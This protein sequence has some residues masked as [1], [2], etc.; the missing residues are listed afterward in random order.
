MQRHNGIAWIVALAGWLL[1]CALLAQALELRKPPVPV[2]PSTTDTVRVAIVDSGVDYSLPLI[3]ASLAR[4]DNMGLASPTAGTILGIDFRDLDNRPWDQRRTRAG[5]RRH[6][7]RVASVL[8]AEAPAVELVPYRFPGQDMRLMHALV[9][10]AAANDVRIIGLPLGSDNPDQWRALERAARAHPRVLFVASAGNDGRNLDQQP[11]YPASLPLDNMLVVTSADDFG[12]PSPESGVGRTT[13]DYLVPAEAVPIV[14]FGGEPGIAAGSSYAVPRVVAMAARM[15]QREPDLG[16]TEIIAAIRQTHANGAMPRYVGQGLI[17][18]PLQDQ[19]GDLQSLGAHDS[20]RLR[21]ALSVAGTEQTVNTSQQHKLTVDI[22][23]LDQ[24]WSSER[25]STALGDAATILAVCNIRI[26]ARRILRPP[27]AAH[28]RLQD[29]HIGAAHTLFSRLER[30]GP[31]RVPSLVFARDTRMQTAFDAEA[32]GRGNTRHR[33]WMTDSVWLTLA[34]E[35]D[36]IAL[37]HE[38]YHV[39]SNDGSHVQ[40]PGNLMLARTTGDNRALSEAQCE[41]LV[42]L[43]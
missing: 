25:V 2:A 26:E 18:D 20:E 22:L 31:T 6:G 29:L 23:I 4:H 11:L 10:H 38:L 43:R 9:E 35:D 36:G 1:P 13:V 34:L 32:F 28:P 3:Y 19:V 16:A 33:P 30:G 8:L 39:L 40:T 21:N 5:I 24:R 14:N 17:V 7:T 15:L 37:A 41:R 27:L 12:R 42:P